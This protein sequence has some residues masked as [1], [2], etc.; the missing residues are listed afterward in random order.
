MFTVK[1]VTL[2]HLTSDPRAY[3]VGENNEL[4]QEICLLSKRTVT[5]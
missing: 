2:K 4:I 5:E 3:T 1:A